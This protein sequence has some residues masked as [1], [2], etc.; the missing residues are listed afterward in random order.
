MGDFESPSRG[1]KS[2]Y[3]Q[4]LEEQSIRTKNRSLSHNGAR[5]QME[6]G[7][8]RE[9]LSAKKNPRKVSNARNQ[10]SCMG[11]IMSWDPEPKQKYKKV[12][13]NTKSF[14]EPERLQGKPP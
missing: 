7:K 4:Y 12:E 13:Y 8:T 3:Q 14:K 2:G 11:S 10:E 5:T 6:F 9:N 1:Q